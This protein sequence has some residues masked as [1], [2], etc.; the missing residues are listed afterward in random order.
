MEE[1]IFRVDVSVI[2]VNYHTE[3]LVVDC[4]RS[5]LEHTD[6]LT[7]E[8]IVADNAPDGGLEAILKRE[9]ALGV[10]PP[11]RYIGLSENPGFGGANN[12]AFN[13]AEGKYCLCLNPD[14]LLLN[15]AIRM[16]YCHMERFADCG[17]CGGNLY[18]ADGRR[19][20]S[21]RRILPGLFWEISE[22][23]RLHPERIRYGRSTRFNRSCRPMKAGYISGADLMLRTELVRRLGGFSS[24][25][26][27]Y[28]EETDLCARIHRS[29]YT[30][31][32]LPDPK[33]VHL[34]GK[35]FGENEISETK[36]RYYE[37]SRVAYYR[38][39]VSEKKARIAHWIYLRSLRRDSRKK[40][41]RGKVATLRLRF[42]M[43]ALGQSLPSKA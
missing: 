16:M 19:A 2:I 1:E 30:V 9:S 7:Y 25:F 40:G 42:A 5:V 23:L 12:K 15:N 17:A 33:I 29:G 4:L 31:T 18:H 39:N 41:I 13:M 27:M 20:L 32:S 36:L 22:S 8:V 26:F 3:S 6:N 10:I 43:E 11:V 37:Q 21:M 24:D 35:S 28:F 34:E 14:T 38:R